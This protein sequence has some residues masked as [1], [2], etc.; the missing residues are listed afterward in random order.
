MKKKISNGWLYWLMVI[1]AILL[2][3][4]TKQ[5]LIAQKNT[6]DVYKLISVH[7]KLDTTDAKTF[8]LWQDTVFRAEEKIKLDTIT[9]KWQPICN[10]DLKK[11]GLEYRYYM[12][13]GLVLNGP[14]YRKS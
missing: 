14:I 13:N 2:F 11:I 7:Y 12:K 4:C 5:E 9:P 10:A 8:V 6:P 1:I 3:S